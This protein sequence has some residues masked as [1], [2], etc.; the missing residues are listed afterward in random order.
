[1][2]DYKPKAS[3]INKKHTASNYPCVGCIRHKKDLPLH[4]RA[5]HPDDAAKLAATGRPTF[6]RELYKRGLRPRL[7]FSASHVRVHCPSSKINTGICTARP[8]E[9]IGHRA[10]W[11]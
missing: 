5:Y 3:K 8:Q 10:A 11:A 9:P 2:D 4:M 1:M 7:L 6:A